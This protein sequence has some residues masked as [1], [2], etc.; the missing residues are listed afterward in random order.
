MRSFFTGIQ[1]R[2][3]RAGPAGRR[4]CRSAARPQA[5]TVGGAHPPAA[6]W[7]PGERDA[8]GAGCLPLAPSGHVGAVAHSTP[9]PTARAAR[10]NVSGGARAARG[11]SLRRPHPEAL[12]LAVKGARCARVAARSLRAPGPYAAG[13]QGRLSEGWARTGVRPDGILAAHSILAIIKLCLPRRFHSGPGCAP[14]RTS[15]GPGFCTSLA[16]ARFSGSRVHR[17]RERSA[18]RLRFYA[19]SKPECFCSAACCR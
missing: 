19:G 8:P 1:G 10:R 17:C 6:G 13:I 11:P 7:P 18:N 15:R 3:E 12:Q 9:R 4:T 2:A 14:S 16:N 5:L